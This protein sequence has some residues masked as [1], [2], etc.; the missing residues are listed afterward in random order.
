MGERGGFKI[1]CSCA[2]GGEACGGLGNSNL[3][4]ATAVAKG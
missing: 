1:V 2:L 3:C 4:I